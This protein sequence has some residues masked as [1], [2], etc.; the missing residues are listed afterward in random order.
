MTRTEMRTQSLSRKPQGKR[1]FGR[2]RLEENIKMDLRQMRC[3]G[4]DWVKVAQDRNQR[5]AF[6]S[7]VTNIW[8]R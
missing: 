1:P 7:T 5:Q 6:I 4:V 8:V 2:P 3:E